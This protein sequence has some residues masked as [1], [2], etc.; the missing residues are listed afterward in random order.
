MRVVRRV[1]YL[2]AACSATL[3]SAQT[4]EVRRLPSG[5]PAGYGDIHI[6]KAA[7]PRARIR[8]WA[9]TMV[10]PDC[11]PAGTISV[12]VLKPPQHGTLDLSDDAYFPNYVA[13]N[14][15][16]DCDRQKVPGKQ[17]F[18]T[19]AN[20]YSGHDQAVLRVATSEGRIRKV[21]I[22]IDVR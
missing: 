15:R 16:A 4:Y 5:T 20:G 10:N 3:A 14:P 11:S 22:D 8:L 6:E 13:P 9:A 12:D 19:A 21:T 7:L 2:L 17:A 18:Y 1:L